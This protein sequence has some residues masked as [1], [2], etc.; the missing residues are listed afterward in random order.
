V[1]NYLTENNQM[2]YLYDYGDSWYHLIEF[3][4]VHEKKYKTKYPICLEGERACPPEDVGSIPGYYDFIR[5]MNDKNHKDHQSMKTWFGGK[6]DANKFNLENVKFHNPK[7][8]WKY[9]FDKN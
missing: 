5:I 7:A 6:Y 2:L 4:G 1:Q 9:V 8:R 3:E